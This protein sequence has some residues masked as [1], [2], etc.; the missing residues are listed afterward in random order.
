MSKLGCDRCG[1]TPNSGRIIG[2]GLC[3]RAFGGELAPALQVTFGQCSSDGGSS[4]AGPEPSST[5]CACRVAARTTAE[6]GSEP[7]RPTATARA[8]RPRPNV[9]HVAREAL[10]RPLSLS[11]SAS[12]ELAKGQRQVPCRCW[13]CA[14]QA[15]GPQEAKDPFLRRRIAPARWNTWQPVAATVAT[16]IA[17][18]PF[19][20][21][22]G[23]FVP[24]TAHAQPSMNS[25][26]LLMVVGVGALLLK[27]VVVSYDIVLVSRRQPK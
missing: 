14:V 2:R 10:A 3:R 26:V 19:P 18:G 11:L 22:W 15:A 16:A 20:C 5:K 21:Q 1:P 17:R 8:Q 9:T 13:R 7:G 27:A 23:V 25:V 4:T 24:C 12:S 6:R